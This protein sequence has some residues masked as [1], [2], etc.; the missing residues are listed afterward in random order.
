MLGAVVRPTAD[1]SL[2]NV[3]SVQERQLSVALDPNFPSGVLGDDR[4][5][6]DVQTKFASLCELA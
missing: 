6:G 1:V 2:D 5:R 3:A 4:K